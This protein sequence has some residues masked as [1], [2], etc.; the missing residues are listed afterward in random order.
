[1]MI[2][3]YSADKRISGMDFHWL[4]TPHKHLGISSSCFLY[5]FMHLLQRMWTFLF[6]R[7]TTE[8]N[9]MLLMSSSSPEFQVILPSEWITSPN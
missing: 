6:A 1:M 8:E 9:I 4:V 5:R 3:F 7:P 2:N